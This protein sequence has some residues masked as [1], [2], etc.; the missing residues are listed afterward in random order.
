MG[1]SNRIRVKRANQNVESLG[2]RKNKKK[3]MPSWAMSLIT[4]VIAVSL[5]LSVGGILLSANGVFT[6]LVTSATSANYKVNA[7]MMTYYY[8]TQYQ[9]FLTNYNSYISYFSLDTSKDLK[10]QTIGGGSFDSVILTGD[11]ENFKGKTWHDYFLATTVDSVKSM[12]MYCEAAAE[13]KVAL[14]DEDYAEIE[15][16]IKDYE[17]LAVTYG[18][19]SVNSFFASCFGN[20]VTKT[21]VKDCMEL[22]LLASKTM[23]KV[24]ETLEN[25]IKD[26]DITTKYDADKKLYNVIDYNYYRFMVNYDDVAKEELGTKYTELLKDTENKKKVDA[27]YEAEIKKIKEEAAELAKITDAEA[28]KLFIYTKLTEDAVDSTYTDQTKST[29]NEVKPTEDIIKAIKAEMVKDIVAEIVEGK[30]TADVVVK[31]ETNDKAETK[32]VYGNTVKTEFAKIINTVKDKSFSSVLSLKDTYIREKAGFI[33]DADDKKESFSDW[34]FADGRKPL[35]IKTINEYDGSTD[36]FEIKDKKSYVTVYQLVETSRKDIEK[37]KNFGFMIFETEANAKAA[38]TALLADKK[39]DKAEFE[40][41]A[42][43]NSKLVKEHQFVEER[44]RGYMGNDDFDAWLFDEKTTEGSLMASPIKLGEKEYVIAFYENDGHENW[45]LDVKSKIL[46][47]ITEKE[48]DRIEGK[49]AV[50]VK[51][52]SLRTV[53]RAG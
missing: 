26:A 41:Y 2:V 24:S 12:L 42:E 39:I 31:I 11:Y 50:E 1:K 6:R 18:Y 17:S 53:K 34:A 30:K 46:T 10:D 52:G 47:E 14:T 35:E 16:N 32:D 4:I 21:D 28:F 45:Y 33:D 29:K 44:R 48:N 27:A 15:Q 37:T 38:I 43:T 9:N 3:G 49:Y 5:V 13:Y 20:G 23:E 19:P 51:D 36:K 22:S 7:N 40:K 25:S 8:N